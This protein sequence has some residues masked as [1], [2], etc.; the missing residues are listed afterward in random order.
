MEQSD[1]TAKDTLAID[2]KV[3]GMKAPKKERHPPTPPNSSEL[4]PPNGTR[5][6]EGR[7]RYRSDIETYI[8]VER[9]RERYRAR[10]REI[11]KMHRNERKR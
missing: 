10:Q 5:E 9:D 3:K 6:K 8:S 1:K 11:E 7:D 4:K 2:H